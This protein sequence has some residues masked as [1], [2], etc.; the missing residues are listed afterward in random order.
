MI[1]LFN[2]LWIL[3]VSETMPDFIAEAFNWFSFIFL[4]LL[5]L[6]PLIAMIT[7]FMIARK[8]GRYD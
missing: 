4:L 1:Q 6:S 3:V 8:V 5:I 2:D 7:I